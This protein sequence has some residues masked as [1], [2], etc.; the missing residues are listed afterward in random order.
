MPT[1]RR[2]DGVLTR[3]ALVL[4]LALPLAAIKRA[5]T[6]PHPIVAAALAAS[7]EDRAPDGTWILPG[8][9][10]AGVGDTRPRWCDRA[11]AALAALLGNPVPFDIMAREEARDVAI[12]RLRKWW[13]DHGEKVDWE[14]M[15]KSKK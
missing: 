14:E 3:G 2:L 11:A 8:S 9:P 7:L 6:V 15:G 4:A 1:S 12:D 13:E 10:G 5:A